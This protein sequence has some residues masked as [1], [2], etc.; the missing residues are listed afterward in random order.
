MFAFPE[1]GS[2]RSSKRGFPVSSTGTESACNAEDPSSIPKSGKS[3][4]EEIGYPLQYSWASM[5]AQM[6]KNLPAIQET[7]LWSLGW[8]D[9]LEEEMITH[10]SIL[11]WTIPMDRG[12]CQATVQGLQRVG[13]D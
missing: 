9:P 13:H 12:A 6:V 5:V 10:F 2:L 4:E 1:F 7:W 11:T 8:E 3:P